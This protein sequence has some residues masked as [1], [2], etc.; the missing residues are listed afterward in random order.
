MG[1]QS[2]P[3]PQ[4][5]AN[6]APYDRVRFEEIVKLEPSPAAQPYRPEP[7]QP[8]VLAPEFRIETEGG[9]LEEGAP[10]VTGDKY[11]EDISKAKSIDKVVK[12]KEE[13]KAIFEKRMEETT[14]DEELQ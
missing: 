13:E 7:R 11:T 6:E 12:S 14:S 2:N 4:K 5:P 9:L 1:A 10:S 3:A 8:A